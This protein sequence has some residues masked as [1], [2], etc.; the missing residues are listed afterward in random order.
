MFT[1]L[2]IRTL[3][4]VSLE[5]LMSEELGKVTEK[6]VCASWLWDEFVAPCKKLFDK[7]CCI[8]QLFFSWETEYT[9]IMFMIKL[10]FL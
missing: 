8:W 3:G 1:P 5:E 6:D 7:F 4:K 2:E 9:M 10:L